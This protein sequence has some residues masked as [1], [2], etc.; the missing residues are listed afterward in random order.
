MTMLVNY[1]T[2]VALERNSMLNFFVMQQQHRITKWIIKTMHADIET[3]DRGCFIPL[4]NYA[5]D[6]YR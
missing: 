6:G 5:R 1:M 2:G 4:L 3:V